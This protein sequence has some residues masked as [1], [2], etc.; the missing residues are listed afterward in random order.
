MSGL[1]TELSA[2][3]EANYGHKREREKKKRALIG[4]VCLDMVC[5]RGYV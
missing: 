4:N 1:V 3:Y 5:D 2:L